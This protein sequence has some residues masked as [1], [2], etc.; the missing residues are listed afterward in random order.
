MPDAHSVHPRTRGE[1]V[2]A[3]ACQP[4]GRCK[5]FIPAHAGNTAVTPATAIN[6]DQMARRFIPAHA[7]NTQAFDAPVG[8]DND[9]VHPRTRG[10]HT[11]DR[12]VAASRNNAGSSPHTRGTRITTIGAN[13][14]ELTGSSPHTRG[15][16]NVKTLRQRHRRT[17][18]SPHTRG[19]L[20][21]SLCHLS[22]GQNRF[23]P[24]HAG[25]TTRRAPRY[26]VARCPVHPRTRGE[27]VAFVLCHAT[28]RNSGSSPHT[29]GTRI[30]QIR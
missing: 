5:R 24:A 7:G 19:T 17:G 28:S 1:H 23:I 20:K 27:H 18:S 15:T 16:H 10:E 30:S 9:P 22:Y 2:R 21:G 3:A 12:K 6:R 4:R 11:P 14:M 29:R 25:N 26:E 13:I 8:G